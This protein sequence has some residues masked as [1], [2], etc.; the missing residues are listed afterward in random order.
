MLTNSLTLKPLTQRHY[1]MYM[2]CFD[3][4]KLAVQIDKKNL[5]WKLT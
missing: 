2:L 4:I 3:S 1:T 5:I